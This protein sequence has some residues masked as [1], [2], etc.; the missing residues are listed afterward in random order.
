VTGTHSFDANGDPISPLMSIY[1][2]QNGRWVYQ[3]QIDASPS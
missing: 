2:V 3:Q 1:E